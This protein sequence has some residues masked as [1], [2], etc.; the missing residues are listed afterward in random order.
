[1][2]TLPQLR[3]MRTIF[4]IFLLVCAVTLSGF[5]PDFGQCRLTHDDVKCNFGVFGPKNEFVAWGSVSPKS[6]FPNFH[7][8]LED[9]ALTLDTRDIFKNGIA[10]RS[11]TIRFFGLKPADAYLAP[12]SSQKHEVTNRVS[13]EIKSEGAAEIILYFEG[14]QDIDGKDKHY[15]R[16]KNIMLNGEWQTVSFDQVLPD[17]LKSFQI[18]LDMRKPAKIAIRKLTFGQV[19]LAEKALDPDKNYILNGGAERGWSGISHN[20]LRNYQLTATG[21][22]TNWMNIVVDHEVSLALD[23]EVKYDGA[24]S[25]RL[26]RPDA[27]HVNGSLR[28]NPVPYAIGKP[29]SLTFY[30]KSEKPQTLD[31]SYFLASGLAVGTNIHV[32]TEWKKYEFYIPAWGEKG[33]NYHIIGDIVNGYAKPTGVAVPAIRPTAA[34][35]LWIDNVAHTIGGHAVFKESDKVFVSSKLNKNT[36]YYFT[37]EPVLS[38]VSVSN[39]GNTPLEGRLSCEVLNVFGQPVAE[40]E[41]CTLTVQPGGK[42]EREIQVE[43]PSTLRGPV[44]AVFKVTAADRSYRDVAYLGVIERN[45]RLSKR[46]GIE[47]PGMQNIMMA[48]GYVKDFRIGAVRIGHASGALHASFANAKYLKEAGLDVLI[49]MSPVH[50][51]AEDP[52]LWKSEMAKIEQNMKESGQYI[53]VFEVKNEPN[54]SPGWTVEKNLQMIGEVAGIMRKYGIK[55]E[56]AGPVPCGTDFTWIASVLAGENAKYLTVVTEHPYRAL[57][58][59][60]D[61]ADDVQTVR[62]IIDMSHPGLPHYATES[63]RISPCQLE[64]GYIGEYYRLAAARDI[65][66]ILQGFSSGLARYYHFA[67]K[68]W[69]DGSEWNALFAGSPANGGTPIPTPTLYALRNVIDRLESAVPVKRLK[70]G[71]DYRCTIFDHGDKRTAVLWKWNGAPGTLTF[72]ENDARQLTAYD[73]V[74]SVIPAGRLAMNECPVY[75]D[76]A[77]SAGELEELIVNRGTLI[78]DGSSPISLSTAVLADN[79]FAVEVRNKTGRPL[80]NVEVKVEPA[81][82]LTGQSSM[83][84]AAVAPEATAKAEFV[85]KRAISTTDHKVKASAVLPGMKETETIEANLRAIVVPRTAEPLTIDGDLADWP[86]AKSVIVLDRNNVDPKCKTEGWG[87]KEDQIRAE[88]RYAWDDNY[89]YTAVTVY[90]QDFHPLP[91]GAAMTSAW[92]YDSLQICYDTIRNAKPHTTALEDDDFEYCLFESAGKAMVTRRWASSAVYDSLGKNSGLVDPLEVPF[93]VRKY[94]DRVVYEAAFSRKAVSPFKLR[95]YSTM[96]AGLIVNINN[97]SQRM[98]WLELTPGIGQAPKRPDQWMDMVLMP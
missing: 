75:L 8:G 61:Y 6:E 19:R 97:G 5:T 49:N 45:S 59:L 28:F 35:K 21:Q 47:L 87:A 44:N 85:L 56:L 95:P 79:K 34:G 64:T 1:M 13:V 38:Q 50:K 98:G 63:G 30:A 41:V 37:D 67:L 51:A 58:E 91:Q 24:Y 62:K 92:Q 14:N 72:A 15:W 12:E 68:V 81:D 73:F 20:A 89:L 53:D 42:W 82:D 29:A 27:K 39:T 10:N 77:L 78:S 33:G 65:R 40:K 86:A 71:V 46:I 70:L 48:I 26:E 11:M 22:Y 94:A 2:R 83:K 4:G 88:L 31:V 60:P 69:P 90:K 57:P 93:A 66:N 80:E 74:G 7:S 25:F 76:S 43:L 9:G 3:N 23:P 32:G 52:Q 17:N 84:I 54:I 18:R 16:A 36:A 96:R 55:G